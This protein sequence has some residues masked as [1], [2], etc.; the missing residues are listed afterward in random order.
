MSEDESISP[1]STT[2]Y[3]S[4]GPEAQLPPETTN[5]A[6]RLNRGTVTLVLLK[7]NAD[8][9]YALVPLPETY[10]EAKELALETLGRYMILPAPNITL[11]QS[12]QNKEG[13]WIWADILP[14]HWTILVHDGSEVGI[15]GVRAKNDGAF[16][17]G[18]VRVLH[19]IDD[20]DSVE[21][22]D[23]GFNAKEIDRP[24]T[25]NVRTYVCSR[26]SF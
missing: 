6:G 24:K 23:L 7:L 12:I 26:C 8:P 17:E 25:Y 19:W 20:G 15:F 4:T 2:D 9:R 18:A 11:R 22:T 21:W 10:E 1:A 16:I 14:H 3:D 5:R 13:D